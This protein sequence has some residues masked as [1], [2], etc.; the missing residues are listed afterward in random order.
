MELSSYFPFWKKITP[1]EQK[2]LE[3]NAVSQKVCKGTV[4]YNGSVDCTGL[5][6]V[7]SGQLN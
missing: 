6:L 7:G 4:I 3:Q 2:L 5:L 1:A